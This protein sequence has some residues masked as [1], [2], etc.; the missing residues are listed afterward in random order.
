[1]PL[2]GMA[3]A[4]SYRRGDYCSS[5]PQIKDT[6][7]SVFTVFTVSAARIGI[8]N[9]SG[10]TELGGKELPRGFAVPQCGM[11]RAKSCRMGMQ[12]T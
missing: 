7:F 1:M 3:R 5:A 2:C 11:A 6:V 12:A 9:H 4:K 8:A 10:Y